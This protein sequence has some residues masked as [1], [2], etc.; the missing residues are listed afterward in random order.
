MKK[1]IS[2][3]LVLFNILTISAFADAPVLTDLQKN[4]L[5]NFGIMVGDEKGDLHLND[6]ITRA[7]AIKMLCVAGNLN[8][9]AIFLSSFPDVT[10]NHWAYK[11]VNTAKEH[12]VTEG[13]ENGN[14]NPEKNI[15]NEEIIKMIVSLLGYNVMADMQGGYPAGYIAVAA[16]IGITE[17]MKFNANSP[18]V[19]NDVA[20]MIHKALDIPVMKQT[21]FGSEPE[22]SIMDGQNGIELE[23]LKTKLTTK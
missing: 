12:G 23:T 9:N 20:V 8:C 21:G 17:N 1:F 5:Y 6:T 14:F 19:R 2:I 11:Y 16:R 10:E 13:D 7:E 15:T 4:D 18:A 3:I 22:Y